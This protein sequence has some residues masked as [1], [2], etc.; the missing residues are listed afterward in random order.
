MEA[1]EREGQ[2]G[3]QGKGETMRQKGRE[4]EKERGGKREGERGRERENERGVRAEGGDGGHWY[5]RDMVV[6]RLDM[7][8]YEHN[9]MCRYR[10]KNP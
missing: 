3:R 10:L 7:Y 8:I 1:R 6:G 4:S 2:K 9:N 5:E